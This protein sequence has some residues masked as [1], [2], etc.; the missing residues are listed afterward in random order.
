MDN[1]TD[2]VESSFIMYLTLIKSLIQLIQPIQS[3]Y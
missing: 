1:E 3:I 2:A